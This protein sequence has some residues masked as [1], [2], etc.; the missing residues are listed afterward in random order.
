V[1]STLPILRSHRS[2]SSHS[3]S[4]IH[5]NRMLPVLCRGRVALAS[6]KAVRVGFLSGCGRVPLRRGRAGSGVRGAGKLRERRQRSERRDETRERQGE[7]RKRRNER[8]ERRSERVGMFHSECVIQT[9]RTL[10]SL[11]SLSLSLQ[12]L[13]TSIYCTTLARFLP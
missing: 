4:H 9:L 1:L 8:G 12:S 6:R 7:E 10:P 11:L 13:P 2:C 5:S 3:S